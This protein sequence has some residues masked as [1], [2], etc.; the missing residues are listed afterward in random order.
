MIV[1]DGSD[2]RR[3]TTG[4]SQLEPETGAALS[5][6][7]RWASRRWFGVLC[8]AA[9]AAI[10]TAVFTSFQDERRLPDIAMIYVAITL[11]AAGLWE[12]RGWR[13]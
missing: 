1:D 11:L 6:L 8:T 10:F 2:A 12:V 4:E 7:G 3:T 9:T 5:H 13:V